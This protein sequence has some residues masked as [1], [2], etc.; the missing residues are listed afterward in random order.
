MYTIPGAYIHY[1]QH[2]PFAAL[3]AKDNDKDILI[4][5]KIY[6]FKF[7]FLAVHIIF[8]LC[9]HS[10][11]W[12]APNVWVFIAQLVEHCSANAEVVGSNP[13]EVPKFFSD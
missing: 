7:V 9:F 10:T 1:I 3:D 11:N 5:A 6:N 4:T 13:V 2:L 8:I 12:P